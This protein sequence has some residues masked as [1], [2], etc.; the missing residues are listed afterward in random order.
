MPVTHPSARDCRHLSTVNVISDGLEEVIC[1]DCGH[2]T[3]RYE[4]MIRHDLERSQFT[5]RADTLASIGRS[6][7]R[8]DRPRL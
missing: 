5:R 4:T 2:V 3:V 1:E 6:R 8:T 7:H